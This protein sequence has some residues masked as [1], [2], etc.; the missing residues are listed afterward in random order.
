MQQALVRDF[1]LNIALHPAVDEDM[2][3][4]DNVLYK[5]NTFRD[6]AIIIRMGAVKREGG[7]M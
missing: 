7:T 3:S 1:V 6:C 2:I 4:N 5:K